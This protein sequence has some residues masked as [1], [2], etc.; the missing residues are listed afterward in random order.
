MVPLTSSVINRRKSAWWKAARSIRRG[1]RT[2]RKPLSM[3]ADIPTGA[4]YWDIV[5]RRLD[6]MREPYFAF[7]IRSD[8][9]GNREMARV[10][11][12]L[13][14][15][16]HHPIARRLVFLDPEEAFAE[17]VRELLNSAK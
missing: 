3:W 1:F 7:A 8:P 17:R 6:G 4:A 5:S 12:T 14:A 13:E 16:P 11:A 2:P 15:L 10:H 9:S